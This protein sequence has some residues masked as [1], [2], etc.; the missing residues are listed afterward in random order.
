VVADA[1]NRPYFPLRS[2]QEA[3][4]HPDGAMIFEG[5]WGGQIYATCPAALIRCSEA[6]LDLLLR[7]FDAIGWCDLEGARVCFE[8]RA[9]G[10]GVAGGLGGGRIVDGV[11]V[12]PRMAEMGLTAA[13]RDMLT[14]LRDPERSIY[15]DLPTWPETTTQGFTFGSIRTYDHTFGK[16]FVVA[17]DGSRAGLCW[18]TIE[19]PETFASRTGAR[20]DERSYYTDPNYLKQRRDFEQHRWGIWDVAFP[21]PMRTDDPEAIREDTQRNL[22]AIL[23]RL[24]RQWLRWQDESGR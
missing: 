15:Y 13:I 10:R 3:Q 20:E 7:D 6:T 24:K 23:P 16:A 19:S 2:L 17:P 11:W 21:C 14:G 9:I 1:H 22:A 18:H 12:H 8:R 5:D 4:A